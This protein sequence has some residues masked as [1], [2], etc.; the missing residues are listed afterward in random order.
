MSSEQS[1]ADYTGQ[2]LKHLSLE[3]LR[4]LMR[5]WSWAEDART[6]FERELAVFPSDYDRGPG[7][8][9]DRPLGAYYYWCAMLGALGDA[10]EAHHLTYHAPL[11][12]IHEDLGSLLPW[13]RVCRKRLFDIP[14]SP[15]QHPTLAD[16][17]RDKD[18]VARLRRVHRA[19][20]DAFRSE[21]VS[22]DVDSLDH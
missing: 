19:F 17:H 6:R 20:G 15:E 13:L 14:A 9:T 21:Q 8:P 7:A 16:L 4:C 18:T 11:D 5:H 3:R 1:E 12:A 2:P 22:R 10:A